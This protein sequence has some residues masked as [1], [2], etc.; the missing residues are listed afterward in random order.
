[1]TGAPSDAVLVTVLERA[2][3][4]GWIGSGPVERHIR[5]ARAFIPLLPEPCA[6]AADL[7]SGGGLPGLVLARDREDTRWTLIDSSA[8]RVE[9]LV[10]AVGELGL[11]ERVQ[12]VHGRAERLAHEGGFRERFD[13][14]VARSFGP[15]AV[16]AEVAA[17]L[18]AP[19]GRVLV[20]D[21]PAPSADRWPPA[22]LAQ[23]A[24]S[25]CGGSGPSSPI[26]LTVLDKIGPAPEAVPR[27][28]AALYHRPRW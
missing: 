17:G 8:R 24:L 23:L 12:V 22:P 20:S 5:H 19:G 26:A 11:A 4:R 10:W 9:H 6:M 7:G 16:T 27:V 1:M 3:Q 14:V 18:V 13:A 2:Q 15:P 28:S 25:R 21:P